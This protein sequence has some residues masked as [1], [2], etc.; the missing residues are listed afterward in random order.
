ML[1]PK[2][3]VASKEGCPDGPVGAETEKLYWQEE[4]PVQV[5]VAEV[6]CQTQALEVKSDGMAAAEAL[7]ARK[8]KTVDLDNMMVDGERPFCAELRGCV[9]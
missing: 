7:A 8:A 4:A 5:L 2:Q 6:T 1:V 3:P 9:E